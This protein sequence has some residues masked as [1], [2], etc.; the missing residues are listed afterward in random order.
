MTA[1]E[2]SSS[3]AHTHRV[4]LVDDFDDTREA[5]GY[6]LQRAGFDVVTAWGGEDALRLFREGYRPCVALLDLRMPGVN[7]WQL[8]DK[9]RADPELAKITVI[10][11]S[12][13]IAQRERAR[14]VGIREF[15]SKP[16]DFDEL[17]TTVHRHCGG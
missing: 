10:I 3:P 17:I 14:A 7:G 1:S 12:G 2:A 15:L 16:V 11:V 8:W 6:I 4:L 9:M 13:D 5:I